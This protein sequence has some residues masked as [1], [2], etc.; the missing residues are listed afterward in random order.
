MRR[1]RKYITTKRIII[2]VLIAL[3][4]FI[5][6]GV[7]ELVTDEGFMNYAKRYA[8][9][10][11]TI[12]TVSENREENTVTA[13]VSCSNIERTY[14]AYLPDTSGEPVPVIYML[15]DYGSSPLDFRDEIQ[16]EKEALERG[17]AVVFVSGSVREGADTL[18]GW[19]NGEDDYSVDDVGFLEALVKSNASKYNFD[20]KRTY[21]AG[22]GEGAAM[23]YRLLVEAN[24]TFS[25]Y[26]SVS[27]TMSNYVWNE[28]QYYNYSNTDFLQINEKEDINV[29]K[30]TYGYSKEGRSAIDTLVNYLAKSFGYSQSSTESDDNIYCV[31]F[32]NADKAGKIVHLQYEGGFSWS[33]ETNVKI[34]DYLDSL[35]K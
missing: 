2:A 10:D 6:K 32:G 21:V 29:V 12:T 28:M 35:N 34:L 17:Y 22:Y 31:T 19:N 15:H 13:V 14:Y 3:F 4:I 24:D 16:I 9:M 33:D 1:I 5:V 26:V 20:S 11:K 7:V 23:V 25:A 30:S 27:G 8:K 18:K